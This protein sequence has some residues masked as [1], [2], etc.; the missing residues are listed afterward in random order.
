MNN[1]LKITTLAAAIVLT[2][3]FSNEAFAVDGLSA[4]AAFSSNY[5]WRGITQTNN[6]S[7]VSGGIDYVSKSGFYAGTWISTINFGD[8]ASY[9][10]DFYFGVA[11]DLGKGVGYDI[12]YLYYAY[13]DSTNIDPSNK[14]NFGELY[15]KLSYQ[16]FTFSANYGVN[17]QINAKWADKSLYL[18]ADVDY[19]LADDITLSAHIGDYRYKGN[20]SSDN[21]VDYHLT[22]SKAGFTFGIYN[23]NKPNDSAKLVLSYTVDI[24]L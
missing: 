12:G 20:F 14:Y 17:H 1:H 5:L 24:N 23:T 11:G 22:L 19:P 3:V 4:N 10:S 7:A 6:A 21:Y 15:G 2:S 9:E 8:A 18:T 16:Y 13:P